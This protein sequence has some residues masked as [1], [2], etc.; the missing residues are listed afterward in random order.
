MQHSSKTDWQ[1]VKADGSG[2]QTRLNQVN[3]PGNLGG[4]LV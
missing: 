3:R 4:S 2:W 1:R